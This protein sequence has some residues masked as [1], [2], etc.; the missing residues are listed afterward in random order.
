MARYNKITRAQQ[1]RLLMEQAV[2]RFEVEHTKR[3]EKRN[4]I[5]RP[6]QIEI[7]L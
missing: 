2:A 5:A 4:G 6:E 3:K 1:L 7:E